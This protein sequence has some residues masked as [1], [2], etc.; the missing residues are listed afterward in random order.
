[1]PVN[2][3]EDSALQSPFRKRKHP[4]STVLLSPP[5]TPPHFNQLAS[6][7][8]S[9]S[10]LNEASLD[11]QED[12]ASHRPAENTGAK[13]P[14]TTAKFEGNCKVCKERIER[15]TDEITPLRVGFKKY[16][17]HERCATSEKL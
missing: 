2:V 14:L 12:P 17:I 9:V 10:P 15:G 11:I 5:E 6:T 3:S 7:L 4:E 8:S 1:M 16:W 13:R